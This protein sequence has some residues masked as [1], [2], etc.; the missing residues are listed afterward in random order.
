MVRVARGG[1]RCGGRNHS[2]T[3]LRRVVSLSG[4]V[5]GGVAADTLQC[6]FRLP[7]TKTH[8]CTTRN[9]RKYILFIRSV[10][11]GGP[12]TRRAP[13]KGSD[14][15][16]WRP[17]AP[18]ASSWCILHRYSTVARLAAAATP[19]HPHYSMIERRN[20]ATNGARG[21]GNGEKRR[22]Q[23]QRG[24]VCQQQLHTRFSTHTILRCTKTPPK[25]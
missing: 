12:H 3:G 10:L 19:S 23:R 2:P 11:P 20:T 14:C 21:R 24:A 13:G 7:K 1:V 4:A 15:A 9:T 25:P 5:R 8:P 22:R 16:T 6:L 17:A 18:R